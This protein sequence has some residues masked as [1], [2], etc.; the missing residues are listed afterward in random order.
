MEK[1]Q[2]LD[3]LVSTD[4]IDPELLYDWLAEEKSFMKRVL[5]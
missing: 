4:D 1:S 5:P 3:A 2:G